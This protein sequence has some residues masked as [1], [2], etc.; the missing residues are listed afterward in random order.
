MYCTL[1]PILK[2]VMLLCRWQQF[3]T[4][5]L[6]GRYLDCPQFFDVCFCSTYLLNEYH[7][8]WWYLS[9][10]KI[11]LDTGHRGDLLLLDNQSVDNKVKYPTN[12]S[13]HLKHTFS[14]LR[15]SLFN[16]PR[17]LSLWLRYTLSRNN[18]KSKFIKY[19]LR[20]LAC[21]WEWKAQSCLGG[22]VFNLQLY[23]MSNPFLLY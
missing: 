10:I 21:T 11:L 4:I 22:Y 14:Y 1:I 9:R 18:K 15:T 20:G 12:S 2:V 23:V 19:S 7:E 3:W 13:T 16:K 17:H 6:L 5:K 8:I